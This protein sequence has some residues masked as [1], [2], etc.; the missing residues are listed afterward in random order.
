MNL[1]KNSSGSTF[2]RGDFTATGAFFW[3]SIDLSPYRGMDKGNTPFYIE[4]LD[5]AGKKATGYIGAVGAG[6]MLGDELVIDPGFDN[7][8]SWTKGTGWTVIGSQ[9]V[10]ATLGGTYIY[11]LVSCTRMQLYKHVMTCAVLTSGTYQFVAFIGPLDPIYNDAGIKT[12]YRNAPTTDLQGTGILDTT[13][14][15]ATF[16]DISSKR[17]HRSSLNRSPYRLLSQWDSEELGKHRE[18]V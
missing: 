12:G 7:S 3:S 2:N 6:E 4:L 8:P 15:V 17:C 10:A 16:N 18:W 1:I 13:A 14:L 9:A 5:G 11:Q